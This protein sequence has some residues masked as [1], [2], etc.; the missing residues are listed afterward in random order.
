[1][2]EISD[3]AQLQAPPSEEAHIR[4]Q[5]EASFHYVHLTADI[6]ELPVM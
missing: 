3:N 4:Q 2:A 5:C 6:A 1:M